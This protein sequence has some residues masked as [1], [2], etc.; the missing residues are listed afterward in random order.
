MAQTFSWF[1]KALQ[2]ILVQNENK[3]PNV[4]ISYKTEV[5]LNRDIANILTHNNLEN[6][7]VS[8]VTGPGKRQGDFPIWWSC[9]QRTYALA[10]H[11]KLKVLKRVP[12]L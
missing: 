12:E 3:F 7:V 10:L 5:Q 9:P 11:V 6:A 4:R 2:I 1:P 8:G